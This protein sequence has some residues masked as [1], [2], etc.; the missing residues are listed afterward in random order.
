[1][2]SLKKQEEQ[3]RK[4][5]ETQAKENEMIENIKNSIKV[6]R[7]WTAKPNSAGGVDLYIN[8][9]NLSDKVIKYVYFTVEPYN[10]VNDT[11][12]CT[13]RRYSEFTAQDDGP[14]KKG[15]GNKRNC[16]LLGKCMV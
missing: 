9:K 10:S 5:A 13:I 16:I 8:W 12:T 7:V 6:T 15:A 3:K 2:D 11:V 1:M 4:E 14:F